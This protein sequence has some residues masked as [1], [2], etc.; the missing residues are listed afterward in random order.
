M[1]IGDYLLVAL[2][3]IAAAYVIRRVQIAAREF[4]RFRGKMLATCPETQRTVAV[5][6]ATWREALAALIGRRHLELSS[7]TRWPER[8]DCGQE[9]LSQLES[10]PETHR[11][12]TIASQWYAGKKCAYCG[13]PIEAFSHVD[14]RP[15][16]LNDEKTTAEWDQ[17]PAEKLPEIM[18]SSLP[19][20]WNCHVIETFRREH[21]ELVIERPREHVKA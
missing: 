18:S 2:L 15:A 16:L 21:P 13:K 9:C 17:V 5:K 19:V 4:L 7:C 1:A 6:I 12:W 11:V 14:H 8:E 20:C 10:D 3:V